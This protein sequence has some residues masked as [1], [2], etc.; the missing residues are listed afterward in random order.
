MKEPAGSLFPLPGL[1]C[2]VAR[3]S[4]CTT[5]PRNVDTEM[6]QNVARYIISQEKLR[7]SSEIEFQ[8]FNCHALIRRNSLSFPHEDTYFGFFSTMI[9]RVDKK[10]ARILIATLKIGDSIKWVSAFLLCFLIILLLSPEINVVFGVSVCGIIT[11][12]FLYVVFYN[13]LR[14]KS[15][16]QS[17][18]AVEYSAR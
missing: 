14:L 10:D 8:Q 5:T 12:I 15:L 9:L 16:V 3:I 13:I 1:L 18:A 11:L 2:R 6:L 7:N 4:F 17:A